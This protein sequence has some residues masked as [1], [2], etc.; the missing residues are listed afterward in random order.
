MS[1]QTKLFLVFAPFLIAAVGL[2]LFFTMQF[3]KSIVKMFEDDIQDIVHTVHYSTQKLTSKKGRDTEALEHFIEDVK[4]STSAREVSVVGSSQ[5]IVASSNPKKVGQKHNLLSGK[6]IIVRAQYGAEDSGGRPVRYDNVQVPIVR[7]N[8]VIGLL[9]TSIVVN[10]SKSLVRQLNLRTLYIASVA[11]VIM[12]IVSFIVLYNLNKPLRQLSVAA[13]HV[14]SGD[15]SGELRHSGHDEIGR[16]TK[17]FNSMTQQLRV[18][19]QLEDRLRSLER[20]AILSEMASSLA[21]EIRNPLNLINLTAD[22]LGHDYLPSDEERRKSYSELLAGLKAEVQQLNKMVNEFLTIGRPSQLK[23]TTFT[24]AELFGQIQILIKQQMM[25]KR[26]SVK[27]AGNTSQELFADIEQMRLV[28]LNLLL[29]AI[30]AVSD[31]GSISLAVEHTAENNVCIKFMD[32]GPG[33]APENLERIFEPYFSK[34]PGGTGLGLSL[35]RR[36]VEEHG[37]TLT[38]EN[39]PLGGAQFTLVLPIDNKETIAPPSEVG[40]A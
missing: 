12:F 9:Q 40:Q 24:V 36:I 38:A 8:Q 20:H 27:F 39:R 6:E 32:N 15:L 13:E 34:R 14:A 11:L 21:H 25:A 28:F 16:L 7:D 37:G 26:I 29:N 30:E 22:H 2:M 19:K 33:I 18:Q 4:S 5:K 10:D 23:K 35:S 17:S 31:D 3:E 1:F